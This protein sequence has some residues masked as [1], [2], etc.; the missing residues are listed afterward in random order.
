MTHTQNVGCVAQNIRIF[1]KIVDPLTIF[2]C[3]HIDF[4]SML[5]AIGNVIANAMGVHILCR[6][7]SRGMMPFFTFPTR[8]FFRRRPCWSS[9]GVTHTDGYMVTGCLARDIPR[10]LIIENIVE[11]WII[12]VSLIKHNEIRLLCE[13]D[14]GASVSGETSEDQILW[15]ARLLSQ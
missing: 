8:F 12:F 6:F 13:C 2:S 5:Q 9:H 15:A 14:V 3:Y 7:R 1:L 11:L 4:I 10:G